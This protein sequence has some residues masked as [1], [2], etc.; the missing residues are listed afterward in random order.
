MKKTFNVNNKENMSKIASHYSSNTKKEELQRMINQLKTMCASN[1][2][3]YNNRL[4]NE[5]EEKN[6]TLS[7]TA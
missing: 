6:R 5:L 3:P 1:P 2:N 7:L 4:L